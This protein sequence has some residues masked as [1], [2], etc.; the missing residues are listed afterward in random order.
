MVIW[1]VLEIYT[2]MICACMMT[3]RPLLYFLFHSSG[4]ATDSNSRQ[5]KMDSKSARAR[6]SRIHGWTI[7]LKVTE[8]TKVSAEAESVHQK[9]NGQTGGLE[10]WE[11]KRVEVES[12]STS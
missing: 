1:S 7:E 2:A 12:A 5:D 11:A 4:R 6:W 9:L 3:I 10:I 8:S